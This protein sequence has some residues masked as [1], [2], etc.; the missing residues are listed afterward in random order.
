MDTEQVART[1]TGGGGGD[2]STN[3]HAAAT[4]LG[5]RQMATA[6]PKH[7][8]ATRAAA[9]DGYNRTAIHNSL[10]REPTTRCLTGDTPQSRRPP[11]EPPSE[12]RRS[13]GHSTPGSRERPGEQYR[14]ERQ[15]SPSPPALEDTADAACQHCPPP[16]TAIHAQGII[17]LFTNTG[18][19]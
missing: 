1:A 2:T 15:R 19:H 18:Q 14:E 8:V 17:I 9:G 5:P 3:M 6:R 7:N 4:T 13:A 10:L 12:T 11:P 16:P